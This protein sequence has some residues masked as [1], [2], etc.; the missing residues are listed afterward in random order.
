M[1][2]VVEIFSCVYPLETIVI[3]SFASRHA[4][5]TSIN[6]QTKPNPSKARA[7]IEFNKDPEIVHF[8][9]THFRDTNINA[10]IL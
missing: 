1:L 3:M 2:V 8:G 7:F 9:G 6:N 10:R 4:M 5:R